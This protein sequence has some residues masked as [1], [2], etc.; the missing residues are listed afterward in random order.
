MHAERRNTM[1]TKYDEFPCHQ[2]AS[3]FDHPGTSAREWTERIWLMF[4][5][6]TGQFQ[7]VAGFGIYPNRNIIDAYTCLVFEGKTQHVVR[8]SRELRP[9]IDEI[10]VGPFSYKIIEGL[11]TVKAALDENEYGIS[12]DLDFEATMPAHEEGAQFTRF[13]GREVENIRRYDQVG[14]ASGWVKIE[15]QTFQIGK[16]EWW[17]ERD[18]SWGIRRGGAEYSET[19]VQPGDIPE[20]FFYNGVFWQFDKWG[21][22]YHIREDGDGKI[23]NFSGAVF[24]PY[25]SGKEDLELASI[26][27]DFQFRTDIPG[28]RQIN[29]GR[30]ILNAVDG[31]SF[32]VTI[33]PLSA[34]YI[35]AG[36]YNPMGYKD[37]IHGL[38]M[39]PSFI[40]GFKLDLTDPE[41]V[42]EATFL[43]ELSSELRCGKEVGY[44]MTEVTSFGRCPKYG[45]EGY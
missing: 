16:N 24:Y 7:I 35:G 34:C 22:C 30:V 32:E 33:H 12:Y 41:V 45:Y 28:I 6:T 39:G 8:A 14:R 15:G 18:H 9:R 19:G 42:R 11:K 5:D 38:W 2:I 26:E 25:G 40:D 1:L 4:H 10:E 31:S 43:D 13:R 44:G 37:F 29:G 3:T 20:G 23:T 36:G 27:H 17:A 21:A